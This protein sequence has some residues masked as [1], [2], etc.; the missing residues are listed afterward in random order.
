MSL[1]SALRGSLAS[2]AWLLLAQ[3]PPPAPVPSPAPAAN[4]ELRVQELIRLIETKPSGVYV[5]QQVKIA[6]DSDRAAYH[7]DGRRNQDFTVRPDDDHPS[8]SGVMHYEQN[9][10]KYLRELVQI[11]PAAV[12]GLVRAATYEGYEF[13]N[14]YARALGQIKDLRAVPALLK[15]YEDANNQL[16]VAKAAERFDPA[17]AA[18]AARKGN[19]CKQD[20]LAAL[21]AVSGQNFGDDLNRWKAWWETQKGAVPAL[22]VPKHYSVESGPATPR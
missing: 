13:R 21:A 11:G 5:N 6:P 3:A 9:Q 12:P 8:I 22:D 7:A 15:L 1:K 17:M 2:L 16:M 18:E 10:E 20:A 4:V 14:L 19:A